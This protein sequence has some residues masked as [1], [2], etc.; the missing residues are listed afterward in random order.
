MFGAVDGQH[1]LIARWASRIRQLAAV[2]KSPKYAQSTRYGQSVHVTVQENLTL[3]PKAR[4][5]NVLDVGN[6]LSYEPVSCQPGE[7]APLAL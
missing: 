3:A 7:E 1:G 4:A 2:T 6:Q 5:T